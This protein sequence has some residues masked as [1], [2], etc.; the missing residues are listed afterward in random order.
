MARDQPFTKQEAQQQLN[1]NRLRSIRN[2]L[3]EKRRDAE[4]A[5][6]VSEQP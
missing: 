6:N 2:M 3:A 1:V 4:E 5:D